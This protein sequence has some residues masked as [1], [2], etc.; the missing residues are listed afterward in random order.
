MRFDGG[1]N[2]R[3]T[4]LL[5]LA[6]LFVAPVPEGSG[7][8]TERNALQPSEYAVKAA[9]VYNFIKFIEWPEERATSGES[10][11]VCVLGD[12]PDASAFE[13]LQGQEVRGR[14]LTVATL[15][16]DRNVAECSVLF[17][18]DNQS[19]KLQRILG[20]V[21]GRPT[22]TVGDT[23]GYA[24]RG[25]MINL[26]L[27]NKRVRFEINA[28]RAKASGLRISAKLMRLASKV[29]GNGP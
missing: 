11:R 5:G 9:F 14:R 22:L 24:K 8:A 27:E 29:Y 15:R 16:D 7:L 21:D 18:A 1:Q 4:L 3:R 6:F 23:E 10:V 12:L 26:F 20:L 19:S 13:S 2:V 17:V 28:D 25:I